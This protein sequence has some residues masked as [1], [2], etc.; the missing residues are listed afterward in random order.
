MTA[1]EAQW[2]CQSVADEYGEQ[3]K[4]EVLMRRVWGKERYRVHLLHLSIGRQVSF[5]DVEEW[6]SIREAWSGLLEGVRV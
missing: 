6:D 4:V 3:A 5:T 2:V 1:E